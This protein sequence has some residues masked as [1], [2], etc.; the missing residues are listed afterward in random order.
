[1][2]LD[3]REK[4]LA[5]DKLSLSE[6]TDFVYCCIDFVIPLPADSGWGRLL[7]APAL[8]GSSTS[9]S[10]QP[11]ARRLRRQVLARTG[12]DRVQAASEQFITAHS[13]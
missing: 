7:H 3:W 4:T 1:M 2:S 6:C 12:R 10:S 8:L 13:G 5:R 9:I 11:R